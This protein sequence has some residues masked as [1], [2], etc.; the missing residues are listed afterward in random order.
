MVL[1]QIVVWVGIVIGCLVCKH[2]H[3]FIRLNFQI[4]PLKL[5]DLPGNGAWLQ[6]LTTSPSGTPESLASEILVAR[7]LDDNPFNINNQV[8]LWTVQY[9]V[10]IFGTAFAVSLRF[11]DS[12]K[13]LML[14]LV[15]VFCQR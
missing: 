4:V 15:K 14:P 8:E 3:Q 2:E 13:Q 9:V 6:N 7:V 11:R 10:R 5:I 1:E 12:R